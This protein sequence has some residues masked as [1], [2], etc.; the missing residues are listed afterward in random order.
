M[1]NHCSDSTSKAATALLDK[2]RPLKRWGHLLLIEWLLNIA[3]VFP[4]GTCGFSW[5]MPRIIFLHANQ[6]VSISY[7]AMSKHLGCLIS[8]HL[9]LKHKCAFYNK[10]SFILQREN[11][12]WIWKT[13][14]KHECRE[15]N[16][17]PWLT[18][19][20]FGLCE[21]KIT[22]NSKINEVKMRSILFINIAENPLVF[23]EHKRNMQDNSPFAF[24]MQSE[25]CWGIRAGN[26]IDSKIT[27]N[28]IHHS[29][30]CFTLCVN[31]QW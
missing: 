26:D 11:T 13:K 22:L 28:S 6:L 4:Q 10:F 21:A 29:D 8:F 12:T 24:P 14:H 17:V 3:Y 20:G 9:T 15:E 23:L 1:K 27:R 30:G 31:F 16:A 5:K 7:F 2:P 25:H 18:E 19:I